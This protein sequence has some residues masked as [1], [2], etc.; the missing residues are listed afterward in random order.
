V[1]GRRKKLGGRNVTDAH[2]AHLDPVELNDQRQ[3]T[4]LQQLRR[5]R[6]RPERPARALREDGSQPDRRV[7]SESRGGTG[8]R[9]RQCGQHHVVSGG[10]PAVDL[11][12]AGGA[13]ALRGEEGM[14]LPEE[15]K[16]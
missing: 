10:R 15:E 5:R 8:G 4:Q 13:G 2:W 1:L 16:S 9:F 12:E 3:L 7:K 14:I 6:R 11:T